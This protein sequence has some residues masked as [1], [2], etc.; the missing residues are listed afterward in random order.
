MPVVQQLLGVAG[1]ALQ[2]VDRS[3]AVQ[4]DLLLKLAVDLLQLWLDRRARDRH[5][6]RQTG[7]DR[8]PE[9]VGSLKAGAFVTADEWRRAPLPL[10]ENAGA[11]RDRGQL[12]PLP[13]RILIAGRLR[14]HER[15]AT[16]C[17]RVAVRAGVVGIAWDLVHGV[18]DPLS[19]LLK[20][21]G[22]PCAI[23]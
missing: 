23:D 4:Q 9:R 20:L 21:K 16:G 8:Q 6:L 1:G 22:P 13:G 19:L 3:A 15:P 11:L 10:R 12:E 5:A 18:P 7:A 2:R 14:D 17:R